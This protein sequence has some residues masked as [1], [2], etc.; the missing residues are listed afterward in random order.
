MEAALGKRVTR[1]ELG[2]L[3]LP[4]GRL[5]GREAAD[6]VGLFTETWSLECFALLGCPSVAEQALQID[7]VRQLRYSCTPC[8]LDVSAPAAVPAPCPRPLVPRALPAPRLCPRSADNIVGNV[9]H[10][11]LQPIYATLS[12]IV[13]YSPRGHTRHAIA[14]AEKFKQ[15]IELKY[16][17]RRSRAPNPDALVAYNVFVLDASPSEMVEKLPHL[18]VRTEDLFSGAHTDG[19]DAHTLGELQDDL[20]CLVRANTIDFAQREKEEMRDLTQASEIVSIIDP[21]STIDPDSIA[22]S[23]TS[24][25]WEPTI[26][27]IFLGN[28]NDVPLPPDRRIRMRT[29]RGDDDDDDAY[30]WRTN[31]PNHGYGYDL[32]IECHDYA[33]FPTSAHLRAAEEH[34]RLLEKRWVERCV[35]DMDG[36]DPKD[37]VQP[38]PP[39]NASHVVHLPFPSSP[40]S[41]VVTIN[42]L[43]PFIQFLKSLLLPVDGSLTYE[44]ARDQLSPPRPQNAFDSPIRRGSPTSGFSPSSLPP[45][46][47]FPTSFFQSS[48]SP[49]H[50][51]YTR[52]R[53][54]S[55]TFPSNSSPATPLSTSPT[56]V[57]PVPL[58]TR[59]LKI[60]IYSA[61]GYTESSVL[62]LSILMA[63][64][65]SSLPEAYLT[66]QVEKR[67][68][69][70]VYQSDL[71]VLRRVE[72]RLEKDRTAQT[73][74]Q[75]PTPHP[76][77][78]PVGASHG[79]GSWSRSLG[80]ASARSVQF[81]N[82]PVVNDPSVIPTG[83]S[84]P[85]AVV[86]PLRTRS[87]SEADIG[88]HPHTPVRPR[89]KTLPPTR[90]LPWKDHQ[91]WFNDPRFD[92]SFPS[93]VL[94]F[95]Y[96]GNL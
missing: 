7:S 72:A 65:G 74:S 42:T 71:G 23:S 55:A 84:A 3:R 32:C 31:D 40:A 49:L 68:S 12:D 11:L 39:P 36:L 5:R 77:P 33:P 30:D 64:R 14:V 58:R 2:R 47:S 18:V 56:S 34:F 53:S 62:A 67:R 16:N 25:H 44:V 24:S 69:F 82:P 89:A 79:D 38:R 90:T 61:D 17:E 81:A 94:P 15:A 60:L 45:P 73:S 51:A 54:T 87:E 41:S 80:H 86:H 19:T 26:G 6:G 78:A 9:A 43:L 27:Q 85:S 48:P 28:S 13:V 57:N 22:G 52:I 70:F 21:T 1:V 96:L 8:H 35:A 37:T 59:P 88:A 46:S 91:V 10:L 20:P 95:L 93:R 4:W 75:A 83:V 66:L 76:S 29:I 50:G 63:L 92:G